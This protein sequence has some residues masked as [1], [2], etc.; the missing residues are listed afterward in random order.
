MPLTATSKGGGDFE[1]APAGNHPAICIQVIDL[2]MQES[3]F[4]VK[5]QCRIS[6]ELVDQYMKDGQPF[7][8]SKYYTVSSHQKSNLRIDCESWRGKSFTLSEEAQFDVFAMAGK[9]CMVNCVLGKTLKGE[10]KIEVSGITPIPAAIVHMA[11]SPTNPVQTFSIDDYNN[12]DILAIQT[13]DSLTSWLKEKINLDDRRS[14]APEPLEGSGGH[15]EVRRT[16]SPQSV[17]PESENPAEGME[18]FPF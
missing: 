17:T 4:G 15:H 18:D 14:G 10:D 12:G 2:G 9:N 8:V 3:Q 1:L 13:F 7:M 5:R 6:W 11:S 16:P